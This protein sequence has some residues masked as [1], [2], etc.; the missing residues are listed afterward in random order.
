MQCFSSVGPSHRSYAAY[1]GVT[2]ANSSIH[3]IFSYALV[4]VVCFRHVP[5]LGRIVVG[6]SRWGLGLYLRPV[7]VEFLL[8][9]V[10]VRQVFFLAQRVFPVSH[11]QTYFLHPPPT[12]H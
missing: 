6:V 5:W 10:A 9:K 4:C 1:I 8:E 11:L 3:S 7:R 2:K 12:I